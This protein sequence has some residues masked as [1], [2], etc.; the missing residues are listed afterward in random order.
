MTQ[1]TVQIIFV[2]LAVVAL[3]AIA[4]LWMRK[5]RSEGLKSRFG[6]EY[7]TLAKHT[8]DESKAEALLAAREKRVAAFQ[9]TPLTTDERNRFVGSWREVQAQFVDDPKGAVTRADGLLGEVMKA[10]GYPVA[11]FE[12]RAADLSVDHAEVVQHYRT[13]HDIAERHERGEAGTED[14]RQAMIHF[15]ALFDDLVNEPDPAANGAPVKE[16]EKIRE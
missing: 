16:K 9:F 3:V 13:A 11:D 10:R 8:G 14:L 7:D 12:Q 1:D 6:A 4:L 5:R 15:R 2:A